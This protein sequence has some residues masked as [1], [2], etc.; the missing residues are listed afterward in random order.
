MLRASIPPAIDLKVV[1]DRTPTIRASLR[2]VE[3]A[4]VISVALVVMVVFLFLRNGRATLIPSVAVPVS[5]AG[6]FWR[7]VPGGYTL[8]N[9]SLMA[10]TMATGFVV[11]D[12][13]VVLENIT[14]HMERA[15]H[16]SGGPATARAK[17]A[18]PCCPSACR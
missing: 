10:L 3:R 11:D 5:L 4:L 14:R 9:L 16:P 8:D 2:E 6:T 13:I 12:A 17:S 18:S 7:D 1:S 15:C